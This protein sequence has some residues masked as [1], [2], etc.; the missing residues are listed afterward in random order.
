MAVN[1][2]LCAFNKNISSF[3]FFF[4]GKTENIKKLLIIN[5]IKLNF[6]FKKLGSSKKKKFYIKLISFFK[7]SYHLKSLF[8]SNLIFE[9][10]FL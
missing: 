7:I 9:N 5:K 2:R 6:A 10:F 1:T 8:F 4:L 3:F